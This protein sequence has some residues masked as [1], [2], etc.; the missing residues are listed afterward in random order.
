LYDRHY[1]PFYCTIIAMR[2]QTKYNASLLSATGLSDAEKRAAEEKFVEMLERT[3]G[4]GSAVRGAYCEWLA[5]RSLLAENPQDVSAPEELQAI[6]RWEKAAEAATR[7]VFRQ[8]KIGGTG[9]FF[10]LHVWNSRT[11]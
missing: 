10:E 1:F 2:A 7:S 9:A 11:H 3:F 4:G 5:A 8:M 6:A